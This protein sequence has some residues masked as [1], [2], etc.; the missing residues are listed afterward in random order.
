VARRV[1]IFFETAFIFYCVSKLPLQVSKNRTLFAC[2]E[3]RCH[4]T[5]FAERP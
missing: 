2:H 3:I 4:E 1:T 5:D